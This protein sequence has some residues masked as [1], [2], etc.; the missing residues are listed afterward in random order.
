M[1]LGQI[2]EQAP[3]DELF[4]APKHPYTKALMAAVPVPDPR[5]ES[6]REVVLLDGEVPNPAD[7]PPGCRFHTRC[8]LVTARCREEMPALIRGA[9]LWDVACHLAA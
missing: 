5:L 3:A 9:P 4:R 8:P 7:P 1:Y 2:V 6:G